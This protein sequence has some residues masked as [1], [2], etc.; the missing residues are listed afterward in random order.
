MSGYLLDTNVVS[1]TRKGQRAN[2]GVLAWLA[3]VEDPDLFLNLIL[4]P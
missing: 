1:E 4:H 3:S 2:P